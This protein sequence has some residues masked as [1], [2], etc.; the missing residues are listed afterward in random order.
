SGDCSGIGPSEGIPT[1]EHAGSKRGTSRRTGAG[2]GTSQRRDGQMAQPSAHTSSEHRRWRSLVTSRF[3]ST[4]TRSNR[5]GPN[6]L[7]AVE[8]RNTPSD[9]PVP[10]H[11]AEEW[12]EPDAG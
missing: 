2:T 5:H 3:R 12:L 6:T 10:A 4:P 7:I 1:K 9:W 11:G 8:P